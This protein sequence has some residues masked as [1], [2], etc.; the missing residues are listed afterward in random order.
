VAGDDTGSA[1]PAGDSPVFHL[2]I[3]KW[4]VE[5]AAQ[6]IDGEFSVLK[7][8]RARAKMA[9]PTPGMA[10]STANQHRLR[11]AERWALFDDG[12][13]RAEGRRRLS[14]ATG[15]SPP[16]RAPQR[17][18]SGVPVPTGGSNGGRRTAGPTPT[19]SR[20]WR[21]PRR[22]DRECARRRPWR[23]GTLVSWTICESLPDQAPRTDSRSR[24]GN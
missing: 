11:Q 12:T 4:Q 19:G 9:D 15:S 14:P 10:A 8:S 22:S 16:R 2:R 7:G 21:P 1:L 6:V 24:R 3:K 13:L 20:A 18:W 17:L 5:A 23:C